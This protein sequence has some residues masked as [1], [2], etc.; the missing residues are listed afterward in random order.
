MEGV[1]SQE[2][3]LYVIAIAYA[4]DYENQNQGGVGKQGMTLRN[5][6]KQH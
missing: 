6:Q 3:E 5:T 2:D 1:W 4:R